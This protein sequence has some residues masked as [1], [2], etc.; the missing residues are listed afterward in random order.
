MRPTSMN[1]TV[2]SL[3]I[4]KIASSDTDSWLG[5]LPG[6]DLLVLIAVQL[7]EIKAPPA[8]EEGQFVSEAAEALTENNRPSHSLDWANIPKSASSV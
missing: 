6:G 8:H 1:F 3:A 4:F 5:R 7:V 2:I